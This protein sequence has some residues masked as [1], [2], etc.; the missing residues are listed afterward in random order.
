[1]EKAPKRRRLKEE[2]PS[3]VEAQ[4]ESEEDVQRAL[5][6]CEVTQGVLLAER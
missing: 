1:M 6:E 5:F 4:L 3:A 2:P